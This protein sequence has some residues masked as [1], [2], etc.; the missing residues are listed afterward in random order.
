MNLT[1]PVQNP[2]P[3]G[4]A[5]WRASIRLG[6][7]ATPARTLL[8]ERQ[9]QGPLKVQRPFYPEGPPCHVYLLHPPGGVVGGDRLQIGIQVQA[10]AHAL[11]TTPGASKFY[12][13][14][15]PQAQ[16]R[17]ILEVNSGTLEWLPQENILFPGARLRLETEI[18]LDA[19]ARFIGW[20][21]HCLGRPVIDER[22]EPGQALFDLV[23]RREQTPLLIDRWRI[24]SPG[25]L[26]GAAGL[27]NH[28]VV[29][30]WLASNAD[31][32][33]LELAR[34]AVTQSKQGVIGLSLL[35]ELLVA[36][37]LGD[38]TEEARQLFQ[39]LWRT[40]RPLLLGRDACP[41]R[42]WAT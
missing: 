8:V 30:S 15:G 26:S 29:G 3:P 18:R 25:D 12:R 40:T 17:Q 37:Y 28:P 27:R 20:E 16:Q 14:A 33:D 13:S 35:G 39:R 4:T 21:I 32:Q 31:R 9:H 11:L 2:E 24:E 38:S 10:G 19:T 42:I 7:R 5:G 1:A 23:L 6:F 34:A 41:P 22:F 36:R